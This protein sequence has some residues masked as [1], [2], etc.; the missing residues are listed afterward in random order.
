MFYECFNF[1]GEETSKSSEKEKEPEETETESVD[2]LD[3]DIIVKER[4]TENNGD[5][6]L[7]AS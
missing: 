7:I 2:K 3:G 5:V 4:T 1:A 6:N